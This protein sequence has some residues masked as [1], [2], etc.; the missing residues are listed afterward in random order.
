MAQLFTVA[1]FRMARAARSWRAF[2]QVLLALTVA[3]AAEGSA[4]AQGHAGAQGQA[5][6]V[7][8]VVLQHVDAVYPASALTERK[9]A[10]VM[11]AAT[12][13]ADG[14]VSK[15]EIL[16]SGGA[17]LDEAAEVAVRQWLFSPATRG[18]KPIASRIKIPFHFAPPAPPPEVVETT[19]HDQLPVYPATPAPTP[20]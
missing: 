17:D 12:V 11:V 5:P 19:P 9:H 7:P 14:H 2:S 16:E 4:R 8:P 3:A 13:D 6:A 18:G 1:P 15:V 20:A 10:D